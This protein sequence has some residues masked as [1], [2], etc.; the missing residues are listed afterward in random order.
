MSANSPRILITRLSHIGDC[1][2]TLPMLFAIKK[3]YPDSFVAWTVESPT[4]KLLSA[5]ADID[6]LMVVP[7]NWMSKISNWFELRKKLRDF[8]FDYVIDP[9]CITKS[10]MLGRIS[11][12]R[13]RIGIRGTWGRELS[14][15]LN[16]VLVETKQDH[17]VDRSMELLGE[18]GIE[19]RETRLELPVAIQSQHSIE[20]T[21]LELNVHE[22]VLINPGASWPSKRWKTERF[23]DVAK[24]IFETHRLRS[25]ISWAGEEEIEMAKSIQETAGDAAVIAPSTTLPE[26]AALCSKARFFVGCDTGPMHIAAA[27]QTPCIGLYGPTRPGDS[28]A[29]GAKHMHVQKWYQSGTSRERRSADN[30]AM[31]DITVADVCRAVDQMFASLSNSANSSSAA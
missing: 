20:K 27:V 10:A 31:K 9:Q 30:H 3:K 5:V 8:N 25:L 26:L 4:Q 15:W 22:Y 16:N 24:Y 7:K 1:I 21:L 23:G 18:L 29:Y 17:L 6:E 14:P 2:L 19:N 28:G 13:K 11:G 12:A